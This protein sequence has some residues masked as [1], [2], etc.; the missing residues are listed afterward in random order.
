MARKWLTSESPDSL[1]DKLI[2]QFFEWD[3]LGRSE[4]FIRSGRPL[5]I[6]STM[7]SSQWGVYQRGMRA[8]ARPFAAEAVRR[9]P[10]PKEA[11]DVLDIGGSH[12]YYSAALCRR[13]EM[14][15]RIDGSHQRRPINVP[16]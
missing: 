16:F 2:F 5:D 7:D 6:H 9:L 10:V 11:R 14:K 1:A 4:E 13:Y 3:L 12:G 8:M 15:D